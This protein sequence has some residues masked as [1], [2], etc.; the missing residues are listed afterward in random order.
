MQPKDADGD[1]VYDSKSKSWVKY[2]TRSDALLANLVLQ[3]DFRL[4]Q[5]DLVLTMLRDPEFDVSKVMMSMSSDVLRTIG[6]QSDRTAYERSKSG[7]L[8][9]TKKHGMPRTVFECVLDTMKDNLFLPFEEEITVDEYRPSH[10]ARQD[11]VNM[12]RVHSAWAQDVRPLL[13]RRAVIS[14]PDQL[15]LFL[16]SV[17][18]GAHVREVILHVTGEFED[19]QIFPICSSLF[20]GLFSYCPNIQSFSLQFSGSTKKTGSH[21]STSAYRILVSRMVIVAI[22]AFQS[23]ATHLPHLERL[24]LIAESFH[25][26]VYCWSELC[27]TL[28]SFNSLQFLCIGG[29]WGV[30][31]SRF[32]PLEILNQISPP[33]SLKT[34]ELRPSGPC[35]IPSDIIS[36]LFL[37]SLFRQEN[38]QAFT[39]S[40][41][42]NAVIP[43]GDEH[44]DLFFGETPQAQQ[45]IANMWASVRSLDCNHG[46]LNR[47]TQA[48]ALCTGIRKLTVSAEQFWMLAEGQLPPTLEHLKLTCLD[49]GYN[50]VHD[51]A[52]VEVLERAETMAQT[53]GNSVLANLRRVDFCIHEHALEKRKVTSKV[54][55]DGVVVYY[56][57]SSKCMAKTS[58]AC[59][60]LGIQFEVDTF[61]DFLELS[62][63]VS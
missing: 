28:A 21:E 57:G 5:L 32:S 38:A 14:G 54:D 51:K 24:W 26:P 41:I 6:V 59:H 9:E 18:C 47:V 2:N 40:T 20:S 42:E 17:Y 15:T 16:R 25:V 7:Q 3:H 33:S 43:L 1:R 31:E 58:V 37:P 56:I 19:D 36:W 48:V 52:A 22:H 11:L 29:P 10:S 23:M 62:K 27:K 12:T 60:A 63:E 53:G 8:W 13:Q 50:Q 61:L 44:V 45:V 39:P 49:I 34:I 55:Q 46:S 35:Y 30:Q 4:D